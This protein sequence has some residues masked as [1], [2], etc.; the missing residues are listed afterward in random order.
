MNA[1]DCD[2]NFIADVS[3]KLQSVKHNLNVA[4][5]AKSITEIVSKLESNKSAERDGLSAECFKF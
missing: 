3:R 4:V 5:S 2:H 1:N